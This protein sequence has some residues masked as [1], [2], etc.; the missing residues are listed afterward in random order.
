MAQAPAAAD[1]Q[2]SAPITHGKHN[3]KCVVVGDGA[4]G[5]TCLILSYTTNS[6][7]SDVQPTVFDNYSF[8]C[9]VDSKFVKLGIW[10]TAGQADF[11]RLRPL[12]YR[13]ADVFLIC[14][15]IANP[16]SLDNVVDKWA[17]EVK[18]HGAGVPIILCGTQM[19]LRDDEKTKKTLASAGKQP[20]SKTEAEA[21]R[22]KIGAKA[23][24]EC[25][26]LTLT[27]MKG[28]FDECVRAAFQR[29]SEKNPTGGCCIIS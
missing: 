19:D 28:A 15:S 3:I 4:V 11:D 21:M 6:F 2:K 25:S 8:D 26:A 10:D 29:Q 1:Q 23:Y 14:F 13:D 9:E 12:S 5:K 20:I 7:P 24:V 17:L 16:I 18:H 27:G 22:L